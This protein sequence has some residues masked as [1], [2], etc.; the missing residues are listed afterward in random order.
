MKT[1][2]KGLHQ[3]NKS[4]KRCPFCQKITNEKWELKNPEV[5][6]TANKNWYDK[7]K[8]HVK[9]IS[10]I[11][12]DKNPQYHLNYQRTWR[13]I[14]KSYNKDYQKTRYATDLN[15]KLGKVLRSRIKSAI[16][17]NCKTGSAVRDLGCSIDELKLY[18]ESRFQPGMTW[19][20]WGKTGWH[21][22]HIK[23][24][25]KFNLE[26]REEFLKACHYTNLQ[27]LWA[28]DNYKKRDK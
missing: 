9:V 26:D 5:V 27:P 15:Y 10:S 28:K 8:D 4:L 20:N 25:S 2:R 7:N 17:A 19:E 6:K 11:W 22:D 23:P 1:C 13:A 21:I 3:Y 24:L 14:H 18:L 12:L 16:K